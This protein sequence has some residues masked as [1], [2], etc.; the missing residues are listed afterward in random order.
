MTTSPEYIAR[1]V[2]R[3]QHKF[4][5]LFDMLD[6]VYDPEIPGVSL[7]DLGVLQDVS[8]DVA[9]RCKV[10]ICPTYSGC[11]ALNIMQEDIKACLDKYG[12]SDVDIEVSLSPAWTTDW[13]SPRGR[14]LMIES[15]IAA[16]E[17][18]VVCPLCQS[19]GVR[20]LSQ[21]GSTACK[22]LYKCENCF[23]TFDY[24]KPL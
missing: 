20:L 9:G 1:R 15:G 4:S 14:Q 7:W 8:V 16:C 3:Q 23:E 22:S 2:F 13:I 11:P 17:H 12:H 5:E 19:R 21:F 18:I 24:F 10:T 6:E